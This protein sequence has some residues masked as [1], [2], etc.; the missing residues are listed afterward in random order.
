MFFSNDVYVFGLN[1]FWSRMNWIVHL[2]FNKK[3]FD[4]SLAVTGTAY[5][6][7]SFEAYLKRIEPETLKW[8]SK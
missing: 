8:L 2:F 1:V 5:P 4:F 3:L 7:T 6:E